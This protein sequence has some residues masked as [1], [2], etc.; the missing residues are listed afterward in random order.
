MKPEL[1]I[2][3]SVY[4]QP[5]MLERWFC[6]FE[7]QHPD[8]IQRTEVVVVDDCG[9]PPAIVPCAPNIKLFRVK[10]DI[11]WNQG[12]ARNLA[13]SK[14]S[15]DR[16]MLVD[17]D[18]TLPEGMLCK[19]LEEAKHLQPGLVFRPALR[20]VATGEFDHSSPNVHL[21]L[22]KD[23]ETIGGYDEDYAGHKGWSDVQLLR[24]M[25]KAFALRDR[26]DL[27]FWLQHGNRLLP[28]AQVITLD[29]SVK[30]NRSLHIRKME[31]L[32]KLGWK[33]FVKKVCGKRIRF[34]WEQLQ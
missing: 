24:V 20:H 30:H 13:A 4:G 6:D 27:W 19:L 3:F 2:A 12:G 1:T 9:V 23:F 28:D 21:M 33:E 25:Q 17:P 10:K 8:S 14:A 22:R 16:L 15:S 31:L 5:T 29:R 32:K 11:P 26:K 34:E 18:M 7:K